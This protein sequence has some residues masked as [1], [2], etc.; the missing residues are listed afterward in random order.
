[1]KKIGLSR[2][3]YIEWVI[4]VLFVCTWIAT[5]SH[6]QEGELYIIDDFEGPERSWIDID[7]GIYD[8]YIDRSVFREG[9][10]SMRVNY[11]KKEKLP[12]SFFA[13]RLGGDTLSSDITRFDRISFYVKPE[14]PNLKLTVKIEDRGKRSIEKTFFLPSTREWQECI[15]DFPGT[16]RLSLSDVMLIIFFA[17]P[18]EE[19]SAGSFYID[20]IKLI[21]TAN[22]KPSAD[23]RSDNPT[24]KN[25]AWDHYLSGYSYANNHKYAEAVKEFDIS[26]SYDPNNI[27]AM[28]WKACSLRWMKHFDESIACFRNAIDVA[29]PNSNHSE[30]LWLSLADTYRYA[31]RSED[32]M[33]CYE[34]ALRL[35]P[36]NSKILNAAGKYYAEEGKAREAISYFKRALDVIRESEE[37][38]LNLAEAYH[39]CGMAE[40]A[41]REY[42]KILQ[43][44]PDSK[45]AQEGRALLNWQNMIM[46][47][48]IQ[49]TNVYLDEVYNFTINK[50]EGWLFI[51]LEDN[52]GGVLEKMPRLLIVENASAIPAN[53]TVENSVSI[54]VNELPED[55]KGTM[56]NECAYQIQEEMNNILKGY[57]VTN[58]PSNIILNGT[59]GICSEYECLDEMDNKIVGKQYYFVR[60]GNMY[61]LISYI[62]DKTDNEKKEK[63]ENMLGSFTLK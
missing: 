39:S 29:K 13:V 6:A 60:N 58:T 53:S 43:V 47:L 27:V 34:E 45:Q 49:K 63:I 55:M 14:L 50:P 3:K 4:S 57:F 30:Y 19:E 31:G 46:Q 11:E 62:S 24:V 15:M 22:W 35:Y 26:L 56:L 41:A 25:L 44:N 17:A 42:D 28:E 36:T 12:W 18:G 2:L 20:D 23:I 9:T 48:D 37:I 40:E 8:R 59:E 33:K 61:V 7:Q 52:D 16:D 10:A 51:P 32:A 38:Q 1:M 54:M 21:R 5:A